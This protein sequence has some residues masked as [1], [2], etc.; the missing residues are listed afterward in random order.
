MREP[1]PAGS[2]DTPFGGGR[3]AATGTVGGGQ[4]WGCVAHRR[5][6]LHGGQLRCLKRQ[7]PL[8]V[9]TLSPRWLVRSG[10]TLVIRDR[11]NTVGHSRKARLAGSRA[12]QTSRSRGSGA[13]RRACRPCPGGFPPRPVQA[14][15]RRPAHAR[16]AD[17]PAH[18]SRSTRFLVL[19]KDGVHIRQCGKPI[20]TRF[21]RLSQLIE[22]GLI[23]ALD[24]QHRRAMSGRECLQHRQIQP[25]DID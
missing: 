14:G 25:L 17:R 13:G 22:Q 5:V 7:R 15:R 16:R 21:Q 2:R 10:R 1:L 9:S 20:A 24:L 4:A 12:R 19:H 3:T 8:P 23:H 6:S 11:Q 18:R